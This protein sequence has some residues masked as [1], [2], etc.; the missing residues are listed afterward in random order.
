[1]QTNSFL[2]LLL[3]ASLGSSFTIWEI[4]SADPSASTLTYRQLVIRDNLKFIRKHN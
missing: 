2:L 3:L 4:E 1:M